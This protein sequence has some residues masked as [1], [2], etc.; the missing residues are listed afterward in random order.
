MKNSLRYGLRSCSFS[1]L[2]LLF[3]AIFMYALTGDGFRAVIMTIVLFLAVITSNKATSLMSISRQHSVVE[4]MKGVASKN[5]SQ[6][7]D[8]Q[9]NS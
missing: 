3:V 9:A 7:D 6:A 5:E 8:T 2:S 4:M 1:V